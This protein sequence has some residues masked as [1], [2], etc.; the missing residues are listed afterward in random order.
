MRRAGESVNMSPPT[1]LLISNIGRLATM[2]GTGDILHDVAIVCAEGRV[3]YVGPESAL[4]APSR[5]RERLDAGGRAVL[6]GLVDCHTHLVFAG[7]RRDEFALRCS[8]ATY[9]EIHAQGGGIA[10][11]K[12]CFNADGR[13]AIIT[14][15]RS[16]IFAF[17]ADDDDWAGSIRRAA[18]ATHREL[19]EGLRA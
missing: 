2:N 8:G 16:I 17:A 13:G 19:A 9:A 10:D 12:P 1:E 6:P 7:D 3:V 14:A 11:I 5:P 18:E 15:S 4:P